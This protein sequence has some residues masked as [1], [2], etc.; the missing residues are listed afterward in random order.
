M[1][2]KSQKPKENV[3]E[4]QIQPAAIA[5]TQPNVKKTATK[6]SFFKKI[7]NKK[8]IVAIG[9]AAVVAVGGFFVYNG[10]KKDK[11][12]EMAIKNVAE[13]RHFMKDAVVTGLTVQFYA[14][15]REEPYSQN[16]VAAKQVAFAVVNVNGNEAFKSIDQIEGT[17][18][19]ANEQY[20]IMLLKNP[21]NPLNFTYDIIQSL[22][23]S[24]KSSDEVEIS[25]FVNGDSKTILLADAFDG[26]AISWDAALKIATET[27]GAKLQG[28]TFESYVTIIN[29]V[30]KDSG[31]FWY[32]QF[33]TDEGKTHY[34]VVAPDGTAIA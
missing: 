28:K 20:P 2:I 21:Y 30:A 8:A 6:K 33:I 19:I 11:V 4:V 27:I 32:V 23:Q 16:G 18:K 1:K 12:Y 17:V 31:A 7:F 15:M 24:P 29:N 5:E 3:T 26:T 13:A 34:C 10:M 25:L 22:S 14:G 9:L